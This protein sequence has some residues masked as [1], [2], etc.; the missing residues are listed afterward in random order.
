MYNSSGVLISITISTDSLLPMG[1]EDNY[2]MISSHEDCDPLKRKPILR[3]KQTTF[4]THD[5]D[6]PLL[7]LGSKKQHVV[8]TERRNTGLFIQETRTTQVQPW[9][10]PHL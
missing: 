5:N 7:A 9:M 6:I 4:E 2:E 3:A 1:P 10:C 8:E